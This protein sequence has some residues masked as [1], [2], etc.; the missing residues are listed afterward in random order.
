M[1]DT[2]VNKMLNKFRQNRSSS[3]ENQ[4]HKIKKCENL[5]FDLEQ[6][7]RKQYH[8]YNFNLF[9]TLISIQFDP[10]TCCDPLQYPIQ[11]TLC[12]IQFVFR[13]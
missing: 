12:D 1:I 8:G 5:T 10:P 2:L 9:K 7:L 4:M 11:F 6:E 13:T 3:F